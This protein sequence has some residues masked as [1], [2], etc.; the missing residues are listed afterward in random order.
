MQTESRVKRDKQRKTAYSSSS[1]EC[2]FVESYTRL[3]KLLQ[4]R[5]KFHGMS[6]TFNIELLSKIV[7]S[8]AKVT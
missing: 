4:K 5:T 8:I 3:S 6:K 7:A 2:W 1:F